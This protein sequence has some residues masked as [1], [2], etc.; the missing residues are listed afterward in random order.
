M[1]PGKNEVA[2]ELVNI[3]CSEAPDMVN[4][5]DMY[6]M[7]AIEYALDAENPLRV[8]KRIQKVSEKFW[9]K[10]QKEE[11]EA[12]NKNL[13]SSWRSAMPPVVTPVAPEIDP[14]IR[15]N[16]QQDKQKIQQDILR[17]TENARRLAMSSSPSGE[18]KQNE[19]PVQGNP[20]N[21]FRLSRRGSLAQTKGHT[22]N[23]SAKAMA[24]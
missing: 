17:M 3:L 1:P 7:T 15:A 21:I 11:L 2:Y 18:A 10:T 6:G 4:L 14:Q 19:N 24:A 23:T 5:E 20:T 9:K 16:I 22:Q 12:Q 8:V 13:I